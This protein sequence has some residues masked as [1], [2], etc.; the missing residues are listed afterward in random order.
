MASQLW[1]ALQHLHLLS[2]PRVLPQMHSQVPAY[3]TDE[4]HMNQYLVVLT[5][6]SR[7]PC[8]YR[9]WYPNLLD[10]LLWMSELMLDSCV[11]LR[12]KHKSHALFECDLFS[13]KSQILYR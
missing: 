9:V 3:D 8:K 1:S 2:K 7:Y 6:F 4:L 5:K 12:H 11:A 13:P 10:T